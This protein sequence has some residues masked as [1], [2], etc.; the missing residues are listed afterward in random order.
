[1]ESTGKAA[2][3]CAEENLPFHNP[4]S[5]HLPDGDWNSGI[6]H[7]PSRLYLISKGILDIVLASIGIIVLLPVFLVI[8]VSVK[9]SDGGRVFFFREMVGYRGQPF[10]IVKFRTMVAD[11]ESYLAKHPELLHEYQRNMKLK[12]DP[13]VTR[14]GRFLRKT[15]L[16]EIPQLFNV[17]SG[18][19]SLVG[20]RAIHKSEVALYGKYAAKRHSVK[21]GLTGLW[22]I[23]PRRH[24]MYEERIPL[25]M[26]YID[27]RSFTL[28]LVILLKTVR[29]VIAHSGV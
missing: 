14:I 15:Y 28:D 1:M 4:G 25:D 12:R 23:N 10:F 29:A 26:Q 8:A 24:S 7:E 11:A 6:V 5:N 22:Q 13:R 19:M 27:Q 3:K 2:Q 9:M 21:P 17:L 16:D 18:H 20:P